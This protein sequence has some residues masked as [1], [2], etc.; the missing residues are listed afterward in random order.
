MQDNIQHPINAF[1]EEMQ[2]IIY[3]YSEAKGYPAEFFITAFLG[4]ASTALGRSVTLTTGNYQAI[5]S[6][7]CIILGK[8]GQVKSE[9]LTD[10]FK[11]IKRYQ[12]EIN[13]RHKADQ[14][15][16]DEFKQNN[17]KAKTQELAP[18]KRVILSDTTPEKLI[19]TLSENPK[20]CGIVYDE[21]AGFV[22]RFNRYNS[23][24]DE[25]MYLSLFNGDTILRD[26]IGHGASAYAKHSYLTIIG[27]TQPS[28]LRDVFFSKTGSGF[29]DR[30]LITQ[31]ENIV[32]Q[33]PNQFGINPIEE[34]K[35][36]TI[37][38]RMLSLEFNDANYNQMSYTP[39]SWRICFEYQCAII[40]IQNQPD[41]NDDLRGI[42]AKIEIYIHKFALL[43]QALEY[44][45]SGDIDLVYHV[46]E[47]S[48]NG[49]VILC[50]YFVDQAQKVRILSPVEMLK[51]Q[52]KELYMQLPDHGIN[53]TRLEFVTKAGKMGLKQRAADD[54]LKANAERSEAKLL[55]KVGHGTY[56]KNLF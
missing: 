42:L 15:E 6:I 30:W 29:F 8:R 12:F 41:V 54:F 18:P 19:I 52:W 9:P 3:H 20:G 36:T 39:E 49:A 43:L 31:P 53:F 32:K 38:N 37:I 48:A 7:W 23:G 35:Y 28:V 21:L 55:F 27:T 47:Q 22:G 10:A 4:A 56:T 11:P 16:I 40:D 1:S 14:Q 33:Y 25:Q 50:K 44:A 51:D 5:A 17:P 34:A 26:R 2:K 46:S 24:A 45:E 13:E